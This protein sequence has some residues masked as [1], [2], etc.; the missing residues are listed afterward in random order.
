ML[1]E[2]HGYRLVG[3]TREAFRRRKRLTH[4]PKHGTSPLTPT[5]LPPAGEGLMRLAGVDI[6]SPA[7]A[8]VMI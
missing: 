8:P 3:R 4:T 2:P 5:P 7:A 1:Y 6:K